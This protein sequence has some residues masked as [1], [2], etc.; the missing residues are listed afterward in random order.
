MKHHYL[1]AVLIAALTLGACSGSR[2]DEDLGP[3]ATIATSPTATLA[4]SAP[5]GTDPTDSAHPTSPATIA[6]DDSA[7]AEFWEPLP[8]G[9]D[10]AEFQPD[11]LTREEL[12]KYQPLPDPDPAAWDIPSEG[13]TPEYAKRVFVYVWNLNSAILHYAAEPE[14]DT[15]RAINSADTVFLPI[16]AELLAENIEVSSRKALEGQNRWV[17]LGD[18][19]V[20]EIGPEGFSADGVFPCMTALIHYTETVD[21]VDSTGDKWVG[22]IRDADPNWLNPSGWRQFAAALGDEQGRSNIACEALPQ[23]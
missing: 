10:P 20:L 18:V 8:E 14:V 5:D 19:E 6:Y 23:P 3:T 11:Y 2:S 16:G 17:V 9:M 15:P 22:Y 7:A 1:A 12:T 13:I 4:T 21:G